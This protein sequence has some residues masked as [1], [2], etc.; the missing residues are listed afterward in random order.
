MDESLKTYIKISAFY[1]L[2]VYV[3]ENLPKIKCPSIKTLG[4]NLMIYLYL[5]N[6]F[7]EMYEYDEGEMF[8][9]ILQ[10]QSLFGDFFV[11]IR[12]FIEFEKI[13][14]CDNSIIFDEKEKISS[15][16]IELFMR[17]I[18]VFHHLDKKDDD[19]KPVNKTA[20]DMMK[21][22]KKHRLEYEKS[23]SKK[24]SIGFLEISSALCA[25]HP[26]LNPTNIGELNYFQII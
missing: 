26:S 14:F 17:I 22:I 23:V 5:M 4:E 8:D 20:A 18:K 12:F 24:D 3:G 15:Q 19:Y 2:S 9:K 21:R 7:T 6:T 13:D 25:R 11:F 1:G 16:N 10:S